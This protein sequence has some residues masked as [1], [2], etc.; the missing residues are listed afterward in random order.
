MNCVRSEFHRRNKK[1]MKRSFMCKCAPKPEF[2]S[3]RGI[4]SSPYFH[5]L[6]SLIALRDSTKWQADAGKK[7]NN[8]Q[9]S[10]SV[11]I[12]DKLIAQ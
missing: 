4:S 10:P 12:G 9:L 1:D 2:G 7:K 6:R 11:P 8:N 5:P 3:E